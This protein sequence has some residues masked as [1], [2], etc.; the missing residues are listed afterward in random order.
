[1]LKYSDAIY[2]QLC[3][4]NDQ[5]QY[6]ISADSLGRINVWHIIAA[7]IFTPES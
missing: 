7:L 4:T 2:F 6:C 1:V 3:D 5:S